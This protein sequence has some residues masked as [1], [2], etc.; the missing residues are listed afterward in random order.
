LEADLND[1]SGGITLRWTDRSSIPG[2][3][4]SAFVRVR[5]TVLAEHSQFVL[6]NPL[7]ELGQHCE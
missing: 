4:P 7:Y 1:G 5:G 3:L 2:I 6:L